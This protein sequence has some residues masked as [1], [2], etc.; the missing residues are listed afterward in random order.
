ML[1]VLFCLK[2]I[3]VQHNCNH[4]VACQIEEYNM[5]SGCIV[6]GTHSFDSHMKTSYFY[7][8]LFLL[9]PLLIR[10]KLL[11]LSLAVPVQ[12]SVLFRSCR[13]V[14]RFPKNIVVELF[15]DS[16]VCGTYC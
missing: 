9:K 12:T 7:Q 11:S 16:V 8:W 13:I 6:I 1:L 5:T 10:H 15:G 4:H 14:K 2:K 3:L